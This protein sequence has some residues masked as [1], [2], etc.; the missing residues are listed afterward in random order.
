M[1]RVHDD[2]RRAQLAITALFCSLG[3]QYATWAS[4]IPAITARLGLS[5]AEVGLLLMA[6]G[7]GAV[8]SFPLVA[9]GTRRLGPRRLALLSA[10]G[11]ALVLPALAA[12]PDYPVALLIMACDG[13]LVGCLN[14]AM[15][16]QGAALEVVFRRNAMT[17]LHATFSAG[18]LA[19][20]LLASGMNLVSPSVTVHF[21]VAAAV[22]LLLAGYA[23]PGLLTDSQVVSK[24]EEPAK[25]KRRFRLTVPSR[26]TLWMG[27]AMVFGTVTEG[28]MNDWSSLYLKEVAKAPAEL[29]PMGIAVVSVMMVLAR[30]LAD[31]RR[32]RWGDARIVRLGSALAAVGLALALLIGGVAPALIGFACVGLGIAAVTPCIY[33]AAAGQGT[34]ALNLVAAMGVTGLLAGPPTIGFIAGATSLVWGL[35]A[36]AASAAL[37]SLCTMQIRWSAVAA[38]AAPTADPVESLS[39]G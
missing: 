31:G 13:V 1:L 21:A 10:L 16:A 30:L 26:M 25:A 3:F 2:F 37:V 17:K 5:T 32:S 36:V 8:A 22:L 18:S 11:L 4:R 9:L 38:E 28:A 12:A 23:A 7:V 14:V 15:N 35:G 19:A 27:C 39:L 33:V 24:K 20:A 6:T 29:V 34:D